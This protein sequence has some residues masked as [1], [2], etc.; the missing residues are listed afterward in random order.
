MTENIVKI[1]DGATF[2][3]DF[4]VGNKIKDSFNKTESSDVS[5]DLKMLLKTLFTEIAKIAEQMPKEEA[6]QVADD[7]ESFTKE[8]IKEKRNENGECE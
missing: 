5:D 3:G 2:Q 4:M 6:K 1:G 7:L 8:A